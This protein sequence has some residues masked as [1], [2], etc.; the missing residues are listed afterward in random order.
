MLDGPESKAFKEIA[1]S[2]PFAQPVHF[3]EEQL[4][5]LIL[6][7]LDEI[8]ERVEDKREFCRRAAYHMQYLDSDY[9]LKYAAAYWENVRRIKGVRLDKNFFTK[10][11]NSIISSIYKEEKEEVR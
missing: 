9:G 7:L 8:K 2:F 5:L 1:K 4:P 11:I 3:S 10:K 6:C